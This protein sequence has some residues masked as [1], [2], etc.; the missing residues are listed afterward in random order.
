MTILEK[1][2]SGVYFNGQE[3]TAF[4]AKL[5]I[6]ENLAELK[7][8]TNIR[9]F[10][11][12]TLSVSPKISHSNRFVSLPDGGQFQCLDCEILE[13]LPQQISSE[14]IVA[15]LEQRIWAAITSLIIITIFLAI[16]YFYGLPVLTKNVVKKIP[17][18]TEHALGEK[19]L[20]WLDNNWFEESRLP[21]KKRLH[22]INNFEKLHLN[23]SISKHL[24]IKFRNSERVGANAFA[25]PGG[26]IVITDQLIN[27]STST[28]EIMAILAHEI[29]HIEKRHLM[30]TIIKGSF[31]TLIVA[32]ITGDAATLSAS[33]TGLPVILMQTKYSIDF[34]READSYAFN[35]LKQNKISSQVFADI[36]ERINKDD[37]SNNKMSFLS[38]H[39]AT[40]ERI[41]QAEIND[42][43]HQ[44]KAIEKSI[45]PDNIK[46]KEIEKR[47]ENVK[48][49]IE[50]LENET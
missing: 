19:V 34:E 36:L 8:S 5:N 7:I 4:P 12:N 46:T 41:K 48:K 26:T 45:Q 11:L 37:K 3:I 2:I 25:L 23:L 10:N 27:I 40:R 6:G 1:S 50:K 24:K 15:W 44:I 16:G 31:A 21:Q 29:G 28:N 38:K 9:S 42:L 13:K 18:K 20:T 30:K 32:T 17:I 39:P 47:I 22:I 49:T 35:L 33:T 43:K 14:G